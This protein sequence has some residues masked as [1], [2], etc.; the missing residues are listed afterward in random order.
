MRG[1]LRDY[2]PLRTWS[3]KVVREATKDILLH[4][5]KEKSQEENQS[6]VTVNSPFDVRIVAS[7]QSVEYKAQCLGRRGS[8]LASFHHV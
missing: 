8:D 3:K 4:N 5:L 6:L 2:S 7:R 1:V